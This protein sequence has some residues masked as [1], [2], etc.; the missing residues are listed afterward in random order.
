MKFPTV[1]NL[2]NTPLSS[3]YFF[4]DAEAA[5]MEFIDTIIAR[6]KNK[7]IKK[8]IK[9]RTRQNKICSRWYNESWTNKRWKVRCHNNF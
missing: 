9:R 6:V 4:K 2:G 1:T 7:E 5:K 3:I 8:I